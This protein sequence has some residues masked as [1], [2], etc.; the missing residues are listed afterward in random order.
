M[1]NCLIWEFEKDV[2]LLPKTTPVIII[3]VGFVQI[4]I[5]RF[6]KAPDSIISAD[7]DSHILANDK[8]FHS[9]FFENIQ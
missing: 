5:S 7:P 8:G 4:Q 1:L 6:Y 2:E 9:C 3:G